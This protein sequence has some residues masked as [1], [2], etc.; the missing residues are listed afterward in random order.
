MK[1]GPL[2][3]TAKVEK[4]PT[5]VAGGVAIAE[6]PA[7]HAPVPGSDSGEFDL[8]WLLNSKLFKLLPEELQEESTAH[9][10]LGE[11]LYGLP[12]EEIGIPA[13]YPA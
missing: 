2:R 6:A 5:Q 11:Y 10:H 12:V 1:I 8:N 4:S 3:L 7:N 13:Y 9:L